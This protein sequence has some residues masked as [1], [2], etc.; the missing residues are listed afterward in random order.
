MEPAVTKS[1]TCA[2]FPLQK[3]HDVSVRSAK[4]HAISFA[5]PQWATQSARALPCTM[6]SHA[7]VG[8]SS[9][10]CPLGAVPIQFR[11]KRLRGKHR[12]FP[13]RSSAFARENNLRSIRCAPQVCI[14][15]GRL[16]LGSAEPLFG[17]V[18]EVSSFR[19]SVQRSEFCSETGCEGTSF[20]PEIE[21]NASNIVARSRGR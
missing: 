13:V 8:R 10:R 5:F 1:P 16:H 19:G 3:S 9:V 14:F 4:G 15:R 11:A 18:A 20:P 21:A 7:E 2:I 17:R 12:D 6:V